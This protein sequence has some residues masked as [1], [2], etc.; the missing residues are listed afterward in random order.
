MEQLK[1]MKH[2]LT[3]C[4]EKQINGNLEYTNAQELGEAVDMIKDLSE[5]IY[6]CTITEAMEAKDHTKQ[7]NH[8]PAA[9]YYG[10]QMTR[11][12]PSDYM[13]SDYP[14]MYANGGQGGNSS[15]YYTPVM[16]ATDGSR[17]S[18]GESRNY[19]PMMYASNGG[20]TSS[21]MYHSPEYMYPPY[22]EH[23]YDGRSP[24]LRRRY[25]DGKRYNDKQS[26]MQELEKYTQ[27]LASDITDMIKD[28][29][30]EEK[31]LLQQ[32]ISM[33]ATKIK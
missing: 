18:M 14:M 17:Q 23:E 1:S 32:K 12:Y 4:V 15:S 7:S 31:T 3:E 25:M 10:D 33:L 2:K 8:Y 6:Y 24:M 19:I 26:Q 27:E 22:A 20:S 30:P 11:N 16:Y 21:Y 28:A 5:A 29:S 13:Y 9:H